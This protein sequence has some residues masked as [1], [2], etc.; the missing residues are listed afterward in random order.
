MAIQSSQPLSAPGGPQYMSTPGP[1][2]PSDPG[3]QY[4]QSTQQSSSSNQASSFNLSSSY[5]PDYLESPILRQIAQQA[6]GMA[7]PIYQWGMEQ[8]NKNQGN[9]DAMMRNALTYSSPQRIASEMGRAQAGVQQGAEAGRQSAIQDLQSYGI[10][11]SSGRYAA[12]DQASRVMSG[13]AAAG[14]GNQQREATTAQGFGMQ[15]Q[16]LQSSLSN[17]ATGYGAA[18]AANQFLGTASQLKFPPLGQTAIG[19]SQATGESQSSGTSYGGQFGTYG[20]TFNP[21]KVIYN[22]NVPM[23]NTGSAMPSPHMQGGGEVG[24]NQSPSDGAKVDDVSAN[25]TAG[26]FVIPKDV[27]EWKGQEFFYKLMAQAR[28]MRA[29]AGTENGT[30]A[31]DAPE[32]PE[33]MTGYANGGMADGGA[34]TEGGNAPAVLA[35]DNPSAYA[36]V[37]EGIPEGMRG[38]VFPPPGSGDVDFQCFDRGGPVRGYGIGYAEGGEVTKRGLDDPAV[39]QWL[40]PPEGANPADYLPGTGIPRGSFSKGFEQQ[41]DLDARAKQDR[42]FQKESDAR[43]G[44]RTQREWDRFNAE[45]PSP[46]PLSL[47]QGE[48]RRTGYYPDEFQQPQRELP[49]DR[50][51]LPHPYD[52]RYDRP[53][54]PPQY[55]NFGGQVV[56]IANSPDFLD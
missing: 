29:T 10:D 30:P 47:R 50:R 13:A 42:D 23:V 37:Y 25:L 43:Y 46:L 20:G 36:R 5:I 32:Q 27:A 6:Q 41:Y 1:G 7:A 11:P 33:Q 17:V 45:N 39:S 26:E 49:Y 48:G 15:N 51:W 54:N 55:I 40:K 8:F 31:S 28:K 12:L 2:N 52:S 34:V 3:H 16:A 21:S 38:C 4:Q 44:P 9:I 14:A 18:N 19:G 24:Y 22:P 35:G 53:P 56:D